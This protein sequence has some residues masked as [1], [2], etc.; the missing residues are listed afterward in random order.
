VKTTQLLG[1][2]LAAALV[3]VT[4]A[5]AG[6]TT[7]FTTQVSPDTQR[8]ATEPYVA[9]DRADGTVWVAW[10]A[11]G[12]HVARSDDGGRS[13]VQVDPKDPFGRDIGDVDIE[14]GGPTPC[15]TPTS[16]C[17]P[18]THRVYLSTIERLPLLLQARLAFTDDRGAHWTINS[19]AAFNPSFIDR[20]WLAVYPSKVSATQDQVYIMYHDF[21]ISQI[22]VAASND[23][24][25][26]F[27]PSVDVLAQN[28]LAFVNSFCN[29][30]PSDIDVDART[31]EVYVLWITADPVQNIGEGCD[32][33]QI[34]NFH[35]V[36]V[37]HSQPAIGATLATVT[38]TW[39]AHLVFDGGPTTNTDELFATL[40]VDDSG[41]NGVPGNVYA[42]FPDNLAGPSIFDIWFSYS[43]NKGQMWS[44]PVKV[45]SDKG[46]HYFPWI[47]AGST[48]RVDFIWL[49]SPDYTP[50]DAEESPWFVTFAQTTNGTSATPK[51]NQT[52]ASSSIMHVGGICTNGVFCAVTG[53]NRDLADSI[54]IAIDRGGSAALAWTDQ[55]RVLHGPTHITYGCNTSQ[56]AAYVGANSG[57]SCKGPAGPK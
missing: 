24:G 28:G 36:W 54:G 7:G 46:T 48:G 9:I 50:T 52:S 34:Q 15:A 55:G 3:L 27:G 17:L 39:D 13:F 19:V 23:G 49:N 51:F 56:Q 47:A 33:T 32:I 12:S 4:T 1:L 40:A 5:A 57:L 29:T 14:V 41:T 21:S 37:A 30:V 6:I 22:W 45:N 20:P 35:Q 43:S 31:G 2:L 42:V 25:Q 18:G 26:T 8:N 11:S 10:Q 53:G 16:S 38:T 44:M